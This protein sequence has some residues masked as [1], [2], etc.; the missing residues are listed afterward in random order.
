MGTPVVPQAQP[1][2][3]FCVDGM[4]QG[5]SAST[6]EFFGDLFQCFPINVSND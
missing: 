6:G 5:V 3:W 2:F 4:T 1:M